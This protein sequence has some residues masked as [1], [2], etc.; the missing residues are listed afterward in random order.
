[1]SAL[2]ILVAAI[3]GFSM[4]WFYYKSVYVKRIKA[5][6]SE[7]DELKSQIVKLK[8]LYINMLRQISNYNDED[9]TEIIEIST[10]RTDNDKWIDRSS[11]LAKKQLYHV[12]S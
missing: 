10:G 1:M 12:M 8:G 7:K 9:Y 2:I 5:I 3:V 11:V 6:E 4:A